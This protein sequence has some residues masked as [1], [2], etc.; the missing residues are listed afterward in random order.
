LV[1]A[2]LIRTGNPAS[3]LPRPRKQR[4][5]VFLAIMVVLA[6]AAGYFLRDLM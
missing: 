1:E 4:G 2:Q 6:V 3:S 5:P